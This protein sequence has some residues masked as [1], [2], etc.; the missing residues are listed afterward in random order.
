MNNYSVTIKYPTEREKYSPSIQ[1]KTPFQ[2]LLKA[3]RHDYFTH[4]QLMERSKPE[5][6]KVFNY[7]TSQSTYYGD[8]KFLLDSY[9]LLI[10]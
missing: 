5:S 4:Y 10:K 1:A 8:W 3:R 2:A 9:Q 7:D 6:A